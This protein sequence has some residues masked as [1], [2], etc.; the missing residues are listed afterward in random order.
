ML[1]GGFRWDSY[2]QST[3]SKICKFSVGTF[4][5][6]LI[7]IA[8]R[9]RGILARWLYL[10]LHCV[11]IKKC[12][13]PYIE[14]APL[15]TVILQQLA[16]NPMLLSTLKKLFYGK[17][18]SLFKP[19]WLFSM[20]GNIWVETNIKI[21]SISSLIPEDIPNIANDLGQV[22]SELK[23]VPVPSLQLEEPVNLIKANVFIHGIF[24]CAAMEVLWV[25][26]SNGFLQASALLFL[27]PLIRDACKVSVPLMVLAVVYLYLWFSDHRTRMLAFKY[28]ILKLLPS[29]FIICAIFLRDLNTFLDES[30]GEWMKGEIL[31]KY[32]SHHRG[33]TTYNVEIELSASGE[34]VKHHART[35][36][37]YNALYVGEDVLLII[38]EGALGYAWWDEVIYTPSQKEV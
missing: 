30:P 29:I 12:E 4:Q 21:F 3:E 9:K 31:R 7:P 13:N 22:I 15:N 20:K 24:L 2:G 35:S 8:M 34:S 38:R 28:N 36:Y 1:P 14:I 33:R 16:T 32:K 27:P 19:K 11:G 23:K 5:E 26:F 17:R 37:Y 25:M 6:G 10:C 18:Q